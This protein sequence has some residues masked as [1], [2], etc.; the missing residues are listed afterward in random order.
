MKKLNEQWKI[1]EEL[2][3]INERANYTLLPEL[4]EL[5]AEIP[6]RYSLSFMIGTVSLAKF[7]PERH[8]LL[9]KI[10]ELEEYRFL[11]GNSWWEKKERA[12][13]EKF[14]GTHF[15]FIFDLFRGM[16]QFYTALR[17]FF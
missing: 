6:R 13:R 2:F 4:F 8:P 17:L 15:E 3:H 7:A 12:A 9:A 1:I 14:F 5:G 16:R 11:V 10:A